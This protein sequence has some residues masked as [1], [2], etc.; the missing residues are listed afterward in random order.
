[1]RFIGRK[2]ELKTLERFKGTEKSSLLVV[3][4]RR[5]IGKSRL[6]QEFAERNPFYSFS[7]I[8]PTSKTTAQSQ[9]NEFINQLTRY[10]IPPLQST[11]W[12]DLFWLLTNKVK[13]EKSPSIILFDEISWMGSKDPD[14]LGKLKNAWDLH[15]SKIPGCVLVLC[16]SAS[17]WIE[18]NI[19]SST[20]FV[21][22]ISFTLTL[23]ELPIEDCQKFWGSQASNISAMEKLKTLSVTGGVPRYLEEINPSLSA[24]ANIQNLCFTKGAQLVE[25]FDHIF[26]NTFLRESD[27]YKKIIS[28]LLTGQKEYTEICEALHIKPTGRVLEYL[29]ELELAGFIKR[30]HTFLIKSGKDSKLS[31]FRLCDNYSRFYL[32]YIE[33]NKTKIN[34]NSF[35]LKT[36][37]SL[38]AWQTIMGLQFENLVLNNRF[39]VWDKLNLKPE[40]ILSENP[41][42]Q[43]KTKSQQG[44]QVDYLI[45]TRFNTLYVCEIKFTQGEVPSKVM[46]EMQDKIK[47]L[48]TPK[49]VSY[50]PVLIHVNGVCPEIKESGY[51]SDIID[52]SQV[53]YQKN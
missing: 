11:D 30:D 28:V 49:G 4:G 33:P 13:E 16:G 25:E 43:H 37:G 6:I 53:F 40:D 27:F 36:L 5:R 38:P 44:C 12:N 45:Q 22:R 2:Q 32:K 51:F 9:R 17:S 7:G 29:N 39:F 15:F 42:F 24:E 52:F 48:K 50:R 23:E 3:R 20:G 19:L 46:T 35:E 1:M 8:P 26:S 14:F 41:Y 34:R 10:G 47:K 21:G 18:K 31:L